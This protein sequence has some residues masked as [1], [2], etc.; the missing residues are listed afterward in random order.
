MLKLCLFLIVVIYLSSVPLPVNSQCKKGCDLALASF[1]VWR[2]TDLTNIA[3]LFSIP[4]KQEIMDYNNRTS[5]PNENSVIAGTRVN[6]PFRC[7]C[8]EDVGFLGHLF[9]YEVKSGDTYG[10]VVSNYSDL[11]SVDMLRRFNRRYNDNNIPSGVNLSVVVNCSCGDPA[12]SEDYGLFLT[13]PLRR[14]EDLAYVESGK[15]V[16]TELIRRY[17]PGMDAKLRAGQGI[18][19]IPA[20]GWFYYIFLLFS[21]GY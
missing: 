7:D 20:K 15:N 8:L 4:T 1:Y 16:S 9:Q 11:T 18:I 17:N 13:Y 21:I 5:I 12:V 2:G 3:R 14:E 6:I 19:Y 10:G